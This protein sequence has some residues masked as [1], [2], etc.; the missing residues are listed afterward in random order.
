MR[1]MERPKNKAVI[2]MA[3]LLVLAAGYIGYGYYTDYDNSRLSQAYQLGFID[4]QNVVNNNIINALNT[5]GF[6]SFSAPTDN[7][8]TV[9]INLVPAQ[10]Q[11]PAQ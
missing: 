1:R 8:E 2:V 6:V 7:N 9:T 3:V 11:D 4:A 10:A 5:Q